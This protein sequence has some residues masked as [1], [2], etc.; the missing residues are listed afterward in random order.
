MFSTNAKSKRVEYRTPDPS[1][2]GYLA[3][4][5]ILMAGIDGIENKIDPG[6][7]LDK[8]IYGLTPEELANIPSAHYNPRSMAVARFLRAFPPFGRRHLT[9]DSPHLPL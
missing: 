2:N 5:A 4:A 7:P 9:F 1:C 3:F 8:D 6:Q